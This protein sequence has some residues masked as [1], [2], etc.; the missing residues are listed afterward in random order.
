MLRGFYLPSLHSV[1][2]CATDSLTNV[3]R[4]QIS[5]EDF[6]MLENC[7]NTFI[8]Q[9]FQCKTPNSN[10]MSPF[11]AD[12]TSTPKS[13]RTPFKDNYNLGNEVRKSPIRRR[14]TSLDDESKENNDSAIGLCLSQGADSPAPSAPSS[15]GSSKQSS[16]DSG[17]ASSGSKQSSPE[18]GAA[19]SVSSTKSSKNAVQVLDRL[20]ESTHI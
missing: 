1:F 15:K 9:K 2:L 14:L 3:R 12:T 10:S 5:P 18:L 11:K 20:L 16:P 4:F 8:D 13:S 6:K 19:P 17:A 7:H